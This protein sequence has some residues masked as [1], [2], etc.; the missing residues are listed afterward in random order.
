MYLCVRGIHF[1][2][3]V[4][5]VGFRNVP[6]VLHLIK[7]ENGEYNSM[8]YKERTFVSIL[9]EQELAT[10]PDRLS[11]LPVF[12]GVRVTRSLV[13]CVCFVDRCLL[14]CPF[15]FGHRVFFPSLSSRFWLLLCYPQTRQVIIPR[16]HNSLT[17]SLYLEYKTVLPSHYT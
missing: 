12:S 5:S 6:I 14:F 8:C 1:V 13:L 16:V 10:L 11:S 3:T 9:V 4:F 17:E 7:T 2:S 15:S